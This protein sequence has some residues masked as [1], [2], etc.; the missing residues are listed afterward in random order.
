MPASEAADMRS[1]TAPLSAAGAIHESAYPASAEKVRAQRA[2][3]GEAR[4]T[5]QLERCAASRLI[6]E[7]R[8]GPD[9]P[10]VAP[11]SGA[12]TRRQYGGEIQ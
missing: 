5:G 9:E 6:R 10:K 1:G 8:G 11:K 12:N 7:M 3:K 2:L 4:G